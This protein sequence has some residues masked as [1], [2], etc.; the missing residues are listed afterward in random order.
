[1]RGV[2]RGDGVAEEPLGVVLGEPALALD[3]VLKGLAVDVGHAEEDDV[4][5]L[6]DVENGDDV[7][8]AQGGD[9]AGLVL[10]V[11]DEV[12]VGGVLGAQDLDG[13]VAL[14]RGFQGTE[15]TAHAALGYLVGDDVMAEVTPGGRGHLIPMAVA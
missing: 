6:A 8:M 10:E 14:E 3:P 12:L 11:L 13:D 15:H 4:A 5:F 2:E 7:G 1:M 9:G